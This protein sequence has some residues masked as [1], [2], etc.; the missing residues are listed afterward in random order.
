[1]ATRQIATQEQGGRHPREEKRAELFETIVVGGGQ[2]GLAV[3]YHLKKRGAPFV[4]LDGNERI[5]GSWRTRTWHSLRLFTPARFDGLPGWPF[6]APAWAF[7][8]SD[9]LA[10]YLEAYAARFELPVRSGVAVDRLTRNGERYVVYSGDR[11]FEADRVV[12]ATGFYGKP[13]IPDFASELD[14]RIVQ[15]HSSEYRDPSQLRSGGVLLV[16][17]GNS[18][19][20]IAMEVSRG[21]RTWLSGRDKGQV[22]FRVESRRARVL[23]PVLWFIASRVLTVRTP[24]GRKIGRAS[25]RERV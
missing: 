24:I 19:A 11:R 21:H 10:D 9:E 14:P 2:A 12:V 3:G 16:G 22:P 17:A 18:G 13:A 7:P 4:I 8:T 6:P 15:M 23:L 1:M 25:C 5:G 20:D